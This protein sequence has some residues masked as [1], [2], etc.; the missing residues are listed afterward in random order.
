VI[1][2]NIQDEI[3]RALNLRVEIEVVLKGTLPKSDY[4][5]KRFLD[6]RAWRHLKEDFQFHY[7]WGMPI[8]WKGKVKNL[9][10]KGA[11][12]NESEFI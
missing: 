8:L 6:R 5:A 1:Q 4:K 2:R 9:I 3:K 12:E 11:N 7:G 10:W